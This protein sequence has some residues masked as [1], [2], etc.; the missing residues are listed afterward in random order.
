MCPPQE[1]R[2]YIPPCP[3]LL[4][5]E[6]YHKGSLY[7]SAWGGQRGDLLATGSNDLAVK[8][9]P[10]RFLDNCDGGMDSEWQVQP[11][12]A[13]GLCVLQRHELASDGLRGRPIQSRDTGTDKRDKILGR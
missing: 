8:V 9:V 4:Q 3:L 10:V 7:C 2:R 1:D 5:Q 13:L 11:P 6:N 12:P